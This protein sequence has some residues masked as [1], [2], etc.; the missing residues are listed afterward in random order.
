MKRSLRARIAGGLVLLSLALAGGCEH[1]DAVSSD[2]RVDVVFWHMWTGEWEEVVNRIVQRFNERQSRIRVRPLVVTGDANTKLLLAT[3]GGA[4]PDM[5][6]QWNQVIPAW[7][8]KDALLPMDSLMPPEEFR[9]MDRWLYPAAREIGT[10]E[11]HFYGLC[12]S[13]NTRAL[14]L[15]ARMLREAG[16]DPD[17][18]PRSIDE[19]D[20]YAAKLFKGGGRGKL[21]RAG[22]VPAGLPHWAVVFGAEFYDPARR[23]ITANDPRMVRA[24]EWMTSYSKQYDV[25]KLVSFKAGLTQEIG[26]TYPFI[27][28]KYAMLADGQWRVEDMRKFAP[29]MEYRVA[30]LPYPHDGRP[31]ACHVNGNFLIIPRGARHPREA[32]EFA[33]F[34]AGWKNEATAAEI[35]TW[36]GWIPPSPAITQQPAYQTYLEQNPHFRPFLQIAASPNVRVTPVIPV[37]AFYWDRL[38]AAEDAALRMQQTPQQAL[39]QVTYEVQRELDKALAREQRRVTAKPGKEAHA[40]G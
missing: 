1:R 33:K 29:Q 2:G 5:M 26:G 25:N 24:L 27:A 35:A 31:N 12:V 28:Q 23:R 6:A 11:G 40:D 32:M 18:P 19:L 21:E 4:P 30:P 38:T 3:A 36:G 22:F 39:D 20:A 8:S 9:G 15:N 34:W 7:A 10:Y 14:L 17:R 16:L 37:Q 13:M